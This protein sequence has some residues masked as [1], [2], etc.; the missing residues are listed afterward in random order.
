MAS[1]NTLYVWPASAGIPPTSAF[2][3]LARRN[4]HLVANFDAA[5]DES[6]DFEGV[7]P[8]HY[9]GGGLTVILTWL[10]ATATTG[11]VVWNSAV[12]RHQ[13]DT[14]DLDSDTFATA[15]AATGTTASATGEPQYTSITHSSGAN[16]DSL[17]VGESFRL[18]VTRDADNGSD[19]MA[20]DAQLL[21]VEV[22]ET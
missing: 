6:I 2:A 11:D 8:S 4:N 22:R 14:D 13:D 7:L 12:E 15:Q 9:S 3:T 5:T 21:R 16:M 19:T 17:A 1:G 10:G 20:G 18:R